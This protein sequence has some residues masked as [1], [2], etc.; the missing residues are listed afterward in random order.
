[1]ASSR[2]RRLLIAATIMNSYLAILGLDRALVAMPAWQDAGP[3]AWAAFSNH[4]DNGDTALILYPALAFAGLVLTILAA[5]SHHR[6]GRQPR[7]ASLPIHLAALATVGGLLVTIKAA[8]I[9]LSVPDLGADVAALQRALDAFQ[10][11]GNIR[12]GLQVAA[13]LTCAWSLTA[14]T[15][16]SGERTDPDVAGRNDG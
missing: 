12:A 1:M 3:E 14:I 11:W 9:M 7:R 8:P 16:H 2:T 15:P 13:F 6:D 5:A 10:F 4:A